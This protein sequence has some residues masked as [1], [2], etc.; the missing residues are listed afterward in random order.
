MV[1]DVRRPSTSVPWLYLDKKLS[2]RRETARCFVSLNISLSHSRA[3]KV[4]ENSTIRKLE[5]RFLFAFHIRKY[6][7]GL[8]CIISEIKR[9]LG[10]KS[11]FF[12]IPT[13]IRRPRYG[14]SHRNIATIFGVV[15]LQWREYPAVKKFESRFNTFPACD[16][17]TE[18]K[19][20]R[21]TE[22]LRHNSPR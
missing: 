17:Q 4:I 13:C 11:R 1:A 20:D 8:S 22:I 16:G 9:D 21:Q 10:R 18:G 5:Y 2:Y 19:A 6:I 7:I 15:K 3:L 14:G 12:F